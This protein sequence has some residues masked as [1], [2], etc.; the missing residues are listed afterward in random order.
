MSERIILKQDD[1]TITYDT[2][3]VL[4]KNGYIEL[5]KYDNKISKIKQGF[6]CVDDNSINS[7]L[8]RTKIGLSDETSIEKECKENKTIQ[9]KNLTRTRDNIIQ[10][11]CENEE[12][13]HSFITLTLSDNQ[14]K[15][16]H[17]D[18]DIN[19][20]S[21][22]NKLF[23]NW[24]TQI[25]RKYD[26][27]SYICVPEYQKRG[28]IHYHLITSLKCGTDIPKQETIKT[29][30]TEKKKYYELEYYNIPYWN[31][32]FSTAYDIE[33]TDDNFNI[34]LYIVKYLYKDIDDRLYGHQ[35]LMKSNDLIK[36]KKIFTNNDMY[37][38]CIEYIKEKG[39]DINE[40]SF[41]PTDKYQI[42]FKKTD[43]SILQNDYIKINDDLSNEYIER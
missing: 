3:I 42:A 17:T 10:Y 32:G 29:Y 38:H 4:C 25:S 18:I 12:L 35:K 20:I 1:V 30:N 14:E 33:K 6:E 34:A 15:E 11:A 9:T 16:L 2:K 36:P 5:K 31:Y 43:T 39:Y 24:R 40:Y 23:N 26:N 8:S 21:Q 28:A 7:F 19:D 27:F 22:A 13:F 37:V 41:I